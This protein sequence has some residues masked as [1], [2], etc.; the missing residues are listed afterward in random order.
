MFYSTNINRFQ[1][2][3]QRG[4]CSQFS[5]LQIYWP[6]LVVQLSDEPLRKF[7]DDTQLS[8]QPSVPL[9]YVRFE[10]LTESW[11]MGVQQRDHVIPFTSVEHGRTGPARYLSG[12]LHQCNSA[13]CWEAVQ[14]LA[15]FSSPGSATSS[16]PLAPGLLPQF[17]YHYAC[18]CANPWE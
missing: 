15:H 17:Q 2:A 14:S 5:G 12:K 3:N 11:P 18:E 10:H 8:A 6:Y 1:P 16:R 7:L 4:L 9:F 13:S